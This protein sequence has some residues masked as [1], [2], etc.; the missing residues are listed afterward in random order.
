MPSRKLT[1][2]TVV[3]MFL[4]AALVS[5]CSFGGS[6]KH[7]AAVDSTPGS[8]SNN[9]NDK[10]NPNDTTDPNG[11]ND[12]NDKN[13]P[14][15]SPCISD[16]VKPPSD[17]NCA[18]EWDG[19]DA[20][21]MSCTCEL[22]CYGDADKKCIISVNPGDGQASSS[23]GTLGSCN[24]A[25]SPESDLSTKITCS[26][27]SCQ[28]SPN[29][30]VNISPVAP[31][32]PPAAAI[33]AER[34]VSAVDV[35]FVVDNS[36]S[37]QDNQMASACAMDSFFKAAEQNGAKYQ[38]GV[39]TTDMLCDGLTRCT[40]PLYTTTGQYG[41]APTLEAVSGSC[42]N[43]TCNVSG[44]CEG[45]NLTTP[46]SFKNGGQMVPSDDPNSQDLLRKLIV[47]GA[48]GSNEEGGL[49]KAFQYFAEQERKG[50][51]DPNTPK[52]IVVISDED[53]NAAVP[54]LWSQG[55]LCPFNA[56][57]RKT[58]GIPNFTPPTPTN[59]QQSCAQDL[60]N[61]YSYY[62]KS[63]NIIVNGL[64]YT[65]NCSGAITESVGKIYEAVIKATGGHEDSV[66]ACDHY[67]D[68]FD[69]VGKSTSTLSTEI[70][71]A[72]G[73]VP[74]PTTMQVIYVENG[75]QQVVPQSSQDGWTLDQN[76]KCLVMNGSWKDKYGKFRIEY[77]DA[78]APA[79]PTGEPT[80]CLTSNVNPIASTIQVS[81][82]GRD[83]PQSSTNGYTYNPADH[84]FTFH[85]SDWAA[86]D[87]ST[88]TVKYI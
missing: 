4:A 76:L 41:S 17:A 81:C 6:D 73:K 55:F 87:G 35:V 63:R 64:L 30:Q 85:G 2:N 80:A 14:N 21:G 70:C 13:D 59:T 62:F 3:S 74:D 15:N 29:Q 56:V 46:C 65:S 24:L 60:I 72:D 7:P 19:C 45:L 52:E 57:D 49:E 78:N 12:P 48:T 27:S 69:S 33:N 54:G 25:C 8:D 51:F 18:C 79:L 82:G 71:F 44:G 77:P 84:C 5:A 68:F 26:A 28:V 86:V 75:A 11:K 36:M 83:V 16:R 43:L 58:S 31:T 47:Q 9:P 20:K 50:T 32:A 10:N 67:K 42:S 34:D 61:F 23:D 37:M 39:L 66:C 53:A 1:S 22:S 40:A 88:C 38:T